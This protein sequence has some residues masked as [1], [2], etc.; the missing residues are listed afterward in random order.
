[1]QRFIAATVL[2]LV[3]GAVPAA[4]RAAPADDGLPHP[5]VS[6]NSVAYIFDFGGDMGSS[7]TA[8]P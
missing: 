6:L 7:S 2:M 4:A 3:L 8:G 1:M 5:Y